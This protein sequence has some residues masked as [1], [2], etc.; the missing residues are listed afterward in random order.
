MEGATMKPMLM[1][2]LAGLVV[3]VLYSLVKV[4]SPAPPVVALVGLFG[5]LLGEQ[6]PSPVK[7]LAAGPLP[8][9]AAEPAYVAPAPKDEGAR[10]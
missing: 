7:K 9:V 6:L 10:P 5:I 8:V 2:L 3:G 1:S 4:R